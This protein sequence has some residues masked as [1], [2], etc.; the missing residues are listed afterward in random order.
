MDKNNRLD[1]WVLIAQCGYNTWIV[2]VYFD[3]QRVID[4]RNHYLKM[5]EYKDC[6]LR[7]SNEP[8]IDST[9]KVS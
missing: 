5:K 7:I 1:V 8:I 2:G 6:L 3:Y 4:C 9:G